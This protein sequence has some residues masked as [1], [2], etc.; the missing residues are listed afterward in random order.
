MMKTDSSHLADRQRRR[1]R[2][3]VYFAGSDRWRWQ[4]VW[5]DGSHRVEK[6]RRLLIVIHIRLVHVITGASRGGGDAYSVLRRRLLVDNTGRLL[7][8]SI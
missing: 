2:Q 1:R 8:A 3:M 4:G 6:P 7:W 5:R